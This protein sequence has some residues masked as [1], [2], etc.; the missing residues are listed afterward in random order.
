MSLPDHFTC[1]RYIPDRPV[2]TD[3]SKI[4]SALHTVTCL[5]Q[6]RISVI[7]IILAVRTKIIIAP[8]SIRIIFIVEGAR[9]HKL[10]IIKGLRFPIRARKRCMKPYGTFSTD[11]ANC[12][13]QPYTCFLLCPQIGHFHFHAARILN[14]GRTF[15]G[16]VCPLSAVIPGFYHTSPKDLHNHRK[17]SR[18]LQ[19]RFFNLL[20]HSDV[21]LFICPQHFK[22]HLRFSFLVFRT[23]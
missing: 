12:T 3:Q 13:F 19:L 7:F 6:K 2:R 18:H 20:Q 16:S 9:K 10:I 4:C 17:F 5:C 23:F 1:D 21:L 8:V 14:M 22:F 11:P 15:Y